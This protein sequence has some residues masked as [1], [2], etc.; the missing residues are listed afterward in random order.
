[1][2]NPK[3]N[4]Y[5]GKGFWK[6]EKA[7]YCLKQVC[8]I[9]DN[10]FDCVFIKLGFERLKSESWAYIKKNKYKNIIY[11]IAIYVDDILIAYT[12]KKK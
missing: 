11:I 12:Q 4:E 5:Y 7:I 1:M 10:K 9:W 6:L 2:E 8:L 3:G